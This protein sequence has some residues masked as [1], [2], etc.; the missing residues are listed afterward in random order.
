LLP[1]SHGS[2]FAMMTGD[3]DVKCLFKELILST[4]F[5]L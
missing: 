2:Q 1:A 4:L 3:L 5:Y